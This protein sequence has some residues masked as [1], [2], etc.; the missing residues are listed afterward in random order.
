MQ[1]DIHRFQQLQAEQQ[2]RQT[3][4]DRAA[5]TYSTCKAIERRMIQ[6]V[7]PMSLSGATLCCG[8][9]RVRAQI[10]FDLTPRILLHITQ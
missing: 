5:H 8:A 1:L 2:T 3:F 7:R 10:G 4:D 9:R 6:L